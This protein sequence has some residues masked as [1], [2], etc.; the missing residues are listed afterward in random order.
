MIIVQL[1]GGLGNQMF[2][3]ALGR[4]LSNKNKSNLKV[5]ISFFSTVK[6]DTPRVYE[7]HKLSVNEE[8]ATAEDILDL[9]SRRLNLL[10]KVI[11]KLDEGRIKYT[12]KEPNLLFHP[13]ILNVRSSTYLQ[14]YWQSE[15]YF[16]R[17]RDIL[18]KDFQV[19]IEP[20]DYNSDL[21]GKVGSS[22]SVS[23]H[24]RRGDYI[25]NSSAQKVHGTCTL[26][27]YQDSIEYIKSKI[28]NPIFFIFSDDPDWAEKNI[29]TK[30]STKYVSRN[31][32]DKNYE[33]LRLMNS[34][35]HNIIAN[36]SFSWWGAWLNQNTD[37]IVIA[38]KRWF[39]DDKMEAQATDIVPKSWIR[40]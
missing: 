36:S 4:N 34:C 32:S 38:P 13:S 12:I 17:I 39:A 25:S 23:I 7:L 35:K 18:L 26:E 16:L 19:R 31:S 29:N 1:N 27:Y 10:H 11:N 15:K 2:Q 37:K 5:D 9:K 14:G 3:Y 28:E 6:V 24:V 21:L 20:D 40:L 33:D 22:N 8:F 30:G